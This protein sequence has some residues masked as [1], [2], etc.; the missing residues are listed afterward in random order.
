MTG[1]FLVALLISSVVCLMLFA[2]HR[3]NAFRSFPFLLNSLFIFIFYLPVFVF[4]TPL[5]AE[6]QSAIV[7]SQISMNLGVLAGALVF[8][9]F[10][11]G[12]DQPEGS[13]RF[14]SVAYIFATFFAGLTGYA[15]LYSTRGVPLFSDNISL[16]RETFISGA[17]VVTW[18]SAILINTSV[19]L[20]SLMGRYRLALLLGIVGIMCFMLSGWRGQMVFMVLSVFF[21]FSYKA[22]INWKLTALAAFGL[23]GIAVFG[24]L[25]ANLSGQALYGIELELEYNLDNLMLLFYL[26]GLYVIGRLNEHALNLNI[27]INHFSHNQLNGSGMLMD[28]AFLLPGKSETISG[29]MKNLFGEWEGG[30]G[31]PVTM[32]GG[33]YADFGLPGVV[34]F[35]FFL[36]FIQCILVKALVWKSRNNELLLIPLGFLGSFWI[37]GFLGSYFNSY[38]PFAII[39][40]TGLLGIILMSR[41]LGIIGAGL[42]RTKGLTE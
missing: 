5:S 32:I 27:A 35:S 26:G 12:K 21:M 22:R 13:A 20:L 6:T 10:T 42:R 19:W 11:H 40:A 36:V 1:Y 33:F 39:Y 23:L 2:V 15:F 24:I 14:P 16:A 9:F 29:Y 37:F 4:D 17:G 41:V 28:A 30:G 8:H 18:P 34:F 25:R 3:L 31:L 7:I 38:L